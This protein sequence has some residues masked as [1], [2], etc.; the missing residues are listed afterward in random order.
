MG[1]KTGLKQKQILTQKRSGRNEFGDQF[2]YS[3]AI[4]DFNGDCKDDLAVGAPGEAPGSNPRSGCVFVFKGTN[5]KLKPFQGINQETGNLDPNEDHDLFGW[6]L[7][8]GDFN[9][10]GKH[11]LVVGAPRDI[12]SDI[13]D[14]RAGAVF[15]FKGKS[16]EL[17]GWQFISQKGIGARE[18]SD[19]FGASLAVG[20]LNKD[21]IDDLVV[22]S[23]GEDPPHSPESGYVFVFL[24]ASTRLNYWEG[25]NQEPLDSND[26]G[27]WFGGSVVIGDF[28]GNNV[29]DIVVGAPGKR[30]SGSQKGAI[31]YYMNSSLEL[32]KTY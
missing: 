5:S 23:P 30:N 20:D 16:N 7:A 6:A 31:F 9:G 21:A 14:I 27:D 15:L 17:A 28:M 13:D 18:S 11:D 2:G 32:V 19:W 8:A 26:F 29:P 25:L 4:G 24:S 12:A 22:G 10:D 3:L 1:S